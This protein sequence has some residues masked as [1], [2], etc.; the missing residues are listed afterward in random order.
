MKTRGK[1]FIL[2]LAASLFAALGGC[3][4]WERQQG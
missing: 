3:S 2:A 1:R 4:S